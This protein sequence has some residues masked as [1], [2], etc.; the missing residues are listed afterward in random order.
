V[1]V[2]GWERGRVQGAV[3]CAALRCECCCF[4]AGSYGFCTCAERRRGM[5]WER[6]CVLKWGVE[7]GGVAV[8]V[9]GVGGGGNGGQ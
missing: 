7:R 6:V 4:P 8:T 9:G 1:V 3:C 5:A 2:Q